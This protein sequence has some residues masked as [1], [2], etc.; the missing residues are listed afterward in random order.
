MHSDRKI[1]P[2]DFQWRYRSP[3][4]DFFNA[5]SADAVNLRHEIKQAQQ[6]LANTK[7]H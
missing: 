6:R 5:T 7:S 4:I 1:A 2:S 3:K